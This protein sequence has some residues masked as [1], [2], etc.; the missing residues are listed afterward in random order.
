MRVILERIRVLRITLGG[1]LLG[2]LI[3][4]LLLTLLLFGLGF[5]IKALWWIALV[6][7]VIWIAGF[8]ARGPERRWYRW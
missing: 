1:R 4:F 2:L 7:A 3:V 6:L 5:T 8:V